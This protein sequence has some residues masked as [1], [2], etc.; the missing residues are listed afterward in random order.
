MPLPANR[1]ADGLSWNAIGRI[2]DIDSR[3]VR[4]LFERALRKVDRAL[5]GHAGTTSSRTP[6][7][8]P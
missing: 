4:D 7:A 1:S 2:L 5:A 8:Q 6:P 3:A